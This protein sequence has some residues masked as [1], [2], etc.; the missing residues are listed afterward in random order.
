MIRHP[1]ATDFLRSVM[2]LAV[3]ATIVRLGLVW[4]GLP[5]THLISDDAYY[6]FV[7]ARHIAGG[8]GP[9]FDGLSLTNGFH[10]LW[11]LAVVPVFGAFP[12][13]LW[14]PVRTAL[15]LTVICDLVSGL[16]LHD[17]VR[18]HRGRTAAFTA[19]AAWF[20]L[21]PTALLGLQGLEASLSTLMLMFLLRHLDRLDAGPPVSLR[22]ASATGI[23]LGLAG[24]A[25]TDNLAAGGLAVIACII[26]QGGRGPAGAAW[27]RLVAAGSA[28]TLVMAPWFI[29][30]LARFGSLVQVSGQ[31]KLQVHELFGG[32][33]WG[34][35]DLGSATLT[36]LH[37]LFPTM[38]VSAKYLCG[39][40]F[41]GGSFALPIGLLSQALVLFLF[42]LGARRR[43]ADGTWRASIFVFPVV[44]L[45][46][47]TVLFG[48]VWRSYATWY[49]HGCFALMIVLLAASHGQ[50]VPATP[51]NGRHP[52][53][54]ASVAVALLLLVQLGQYPLY[55]TRIE[56]GARGPEKQFRAPLDRL[57]ALK[58]EGA[59]IGAFD[60]GALAYVA[61]QYDGF[62]VINL[63]GLVN[64]EI[65]RAYRE[66]R[67]A[68][69]VMTHVDIVVQDVRRARLFCSPADVERLLKHY[70]QAQP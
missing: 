8:A 19:A 35:G 14:L 65:Y 6:Y 67:Y 46:A 59:R 31:V 68:D 24:L 45:L 40:Q 41:D 51:G 61:G 39:E 70:G 60:A 58:P 18:R 53:P 10:P 50:S 7:T 2:P 3:L 1:A 43:W 9:T 13:D 22:S 52:A 33:P 38:L 26:L 57:K 42:A 69:W 12:G 64:N 4:L 37:M 20:V 21:P 56:L 54:F 27:R 47:H 23:W 25:R 32:L 48:T 62:T 11:M 66:D 30:N 36:L 17:L 49:A 34:W 5:E 55:L 16:F 44:V 15:S 28:A 63:D 29:W